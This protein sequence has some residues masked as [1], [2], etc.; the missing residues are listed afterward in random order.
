M[1]VGA[2]GVRAIMIAGR[3]MG[4]AWPRFVLFVT[5]P[6]TGAAAGKHHSVWPELPAISVLGAGLMVIAPMRFRASVW[7]VPARYVMWLIMPGAQRSHRSVSTHPEAPSVRPVET[8]TT[9]TVR[10][11][12]ALAVVVK[13]VSWA[14]VV[15]VIA[16]RLSVLRATMET[17][18]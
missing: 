11:I 9:V 2:S 14:R 5:Q 10:L 1:T 13:F 12:N 8:I 17:S 16:T 7:L 6:T 3:Q 18:A 4:S 15:A